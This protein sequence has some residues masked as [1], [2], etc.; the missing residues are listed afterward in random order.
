[1]A[2]C[3]PVLYYHRKW[4]GLSFSCNDWPIFRIYYIKLHQKQNIDIDTLSKETQTN[5]SIPKHGANGK[6]T[7][8]GDR[9][10]G[11]FSALE[12]IHLTVGQIRQQSSALQFIGIPLLS[13]EIKSNFEKLKVC[14][15]PDS[16]YKFSKN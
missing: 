8:Q 5:I 9:K 4:N 16:W 14:I 12:K 6:I 7:I 3:R 15:W 11:I 1:M 10:E 2:N 13:D